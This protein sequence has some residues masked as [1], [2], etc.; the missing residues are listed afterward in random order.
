[1]GTAE[2][3]RALPMHHKL[4]VHGSEYRLTLVASDRRGFVNVTADRCQ[5]P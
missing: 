3:R 5:F 2:I 1:M 4:A